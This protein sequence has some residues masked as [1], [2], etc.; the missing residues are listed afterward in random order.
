MHR[1][2]DDMNDLEEKQKALRN[3]IVKKQTK[4]L[5]N[6]AKKLSKKSQQSL[7]SLKEEEE[8]LDSEPSV[9]QIEQVDKSEKTHTP[10]PDRP[11]ALKVDSK[12]PTP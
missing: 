7:D 3:Q 5:A 8:N 2:F 10:T 9:A 6:V 11:P 12:A 1:F 4:I